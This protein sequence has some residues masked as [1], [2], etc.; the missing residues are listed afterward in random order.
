MFRYK[1]FFGIHVE[2]YQDN[3]GGTYRHR[4]L[5][6]IENDVNIIY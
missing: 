2:E 5:V 6:N 3:F 4:Y 1:V